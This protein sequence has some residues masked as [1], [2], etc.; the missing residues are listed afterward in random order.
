MVPSILFYMVMNW[1]PRG[2]EFRLSYS[3]RL[4]FYGTV[5]LSGVAVREMT[6]YLRNQAQKEQF[7]SEVVFRVAWLHE[8]FS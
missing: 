2:H 4:S 3:P 5:W 8:D 7:V 1:H 6:V